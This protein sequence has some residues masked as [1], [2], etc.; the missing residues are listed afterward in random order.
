M[1]LQN[2]GGA[3]IGGVSHE[4]MRGQPGGGDDP[5]GFGLCTLPGELE[6]ED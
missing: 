6:D 3:I 5:A 1:T 2:G 4:T